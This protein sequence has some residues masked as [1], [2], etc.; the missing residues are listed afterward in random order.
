MIGETVEGADNV[1][2]SEVGVELGCD[3]EGR[4]EVGN[5]EVGAKVGVLVLE[6]T[7]VLGNLVT[8]WLVVGRGDGRM[9]AGGGTQEHPQTPT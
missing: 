2:K 8:G 4:A 5:A 3:E 1:G 9:G 7:V 6:G